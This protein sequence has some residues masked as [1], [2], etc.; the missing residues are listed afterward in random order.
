MGKENWFLCGEKNPNKSKR[1]NI[2]SFHLYKVSRKSKLIETKIIQVVH[3]DSR[4]E[5]IRTY[6]LK[7]TELLFMM[8]KV[9][10]MGSSDG[11]AIL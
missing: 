5:T 9:F 2:V 1:T 10:E 3:R 4:E 8:K 6:C 7:G 11:W